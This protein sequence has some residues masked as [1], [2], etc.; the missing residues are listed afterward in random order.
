MKPSEMIYRSNLAAVYFET[1]EYENCVKTSTE[2]IEIGMKTGN[3]SKLI[4]KVYDIGRL[5]NVKEPSS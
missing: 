3:D 5:N 2:A 4:A 1:K